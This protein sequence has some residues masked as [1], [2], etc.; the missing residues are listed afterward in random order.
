MTKALEGTGLRAQP[1]LTYLANSLRIGDREIPYSLVTA[2]NDPNGSNASS[3]PNEIV[4]NDWAAREL[5][6]EAGR[7]R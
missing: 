5:A 1:M 3:D 6:R 4:L 2:L 7:L